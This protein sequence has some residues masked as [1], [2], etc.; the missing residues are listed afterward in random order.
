MVETHVETQDLASL[1]TPTPS[2][3]QFGPQSKNLAS[4]IRGFKIGVTK[5]AKKRNIPFQ[6]QP[7][8]YDK[9][10]RDEKALNNVRQYIVQNPLNWHKDS[11]NPDLKQ[12]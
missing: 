9:T 2:K 4:I 11:V 6:W 3:N 7:R 8:Y 10:I 5:Y 1:Q 12:K